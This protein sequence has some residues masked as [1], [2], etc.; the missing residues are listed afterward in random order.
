MTKKEAVE[1][2]EEYVLPEV[3]RV[4]GRRDRPAVREAWNNYTDMLQKD[5]RIT[6]RQYDTWVGPY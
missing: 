6:A 1:E 2:F 5:G 3:L 4:Y